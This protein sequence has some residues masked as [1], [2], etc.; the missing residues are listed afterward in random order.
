[1]CSSNHTS[2]GTQAHTLFSQGY[3]TPQNCP[4]DF[5]AVFVMPFLSQHDSIQGYTFHSPL[6]GFKEVLAF[7]L[8]G[9]KPNDGLSDYLSA[10]KPG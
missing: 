9:R 2:T 5:S 3:F 7:K 6:G 8:G 1:M 10:K 4:L